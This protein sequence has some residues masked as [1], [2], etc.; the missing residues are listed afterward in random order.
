MSFQVV[1]GMDRK[2]KS[3][4]SQGHRAVFVQSRFLPSTLARTYTGS[5]LSVVHLAS[6]KRSAR[7]DRDWIGTWAS[8]KMLRCCWL[9]KTR[10]LLH[11]DSYSLVRAS[12]DFDLMRLQRLPLFREW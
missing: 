5:P 9:S 12:Q 1:L 10:E 8:Q 6:C 11:S 7:G 2:L 3:C 4:A